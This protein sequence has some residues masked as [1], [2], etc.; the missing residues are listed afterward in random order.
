M[1]K[2]QRGKQ[3]GFTLIELVV[4]IVI[5]GIISAI[6]APRYVDLKSSAQTSANKANSKAVKSAW[7]MLYGQNQ[8]EPTLTQLQAGIDGT[9]TIQ[10]SNA[11]ICV[12]NGYLV[13]TYKDVAM[14]TATTLATD[15]VKGVSATAA[16]VGGLTCP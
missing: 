10:G 5:I 4:V 13:Q 2:I 11:G 7:N 14:T 12:G 1:N 9:S 15:V 8:T 3:K 16:V 6:M